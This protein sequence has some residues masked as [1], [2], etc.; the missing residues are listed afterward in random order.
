M[1]IKR[2]KKRATEKEPVARPSSNGV[3]LKNQKRAALL[4]RR[5]AELD[6]LLAM[7]NSENEKSTALW[8]SH[9]PRFVP[10]TTPKL[11]QRLPRDNG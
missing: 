5:I 10:W 7:L 2:L 9:S 8:K 1:P 4:R 6:R 3:N 11:W